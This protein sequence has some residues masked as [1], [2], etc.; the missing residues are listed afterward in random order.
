[1]VQRTIEYYNKCTSTIPA[2]TLRQWQQE[3]KLAESRR[4]TEPSAMDIVG[5]QEDNINTNSG[6]NTSNPNQNT[7]VDPQ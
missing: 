6:E 2:R 4:L 7:G 5:V 3:I 1:M